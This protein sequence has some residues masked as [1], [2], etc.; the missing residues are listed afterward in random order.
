MAVSPYHP[1]EIGSKRREKGLARSGNADSAGNNP[2]GVA[3]L[4][5]FQKKHA[6]SALVWQRTE[7][8]GQRQDDG[9]A[10]ALKLLM[11][12]G[13]LV[14]NGIV[15]TAFGCARSMNG[16]LNR[17]VNPNSF[18][19]PCPLARS[20]VAMTVRVGGVPRLA[21]AFDAALLM[22]PRRLGLRRR[23]A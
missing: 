22:G 18:G 15:L 10:L 8:A 13:F 14:R 17:R 2:A 5:G 16:M 23:C 3:L 12:G 7:N 20:R 19:R 1:D 6:L 11:R 21:M 4:D 9:F